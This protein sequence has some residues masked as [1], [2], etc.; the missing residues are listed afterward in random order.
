MA[1]PDGGVALAV[2]T[3]QMHPIYVYGGVWRRAIA[4]ALDAVILAVLAG[5]LSIP[6]ASAIPSLEDRAVRFMFTMGVAVGDG[7]GVLL[8]LAYFLILTTWT[9]ATFGKRILGLRVVDVDGRPPRLARI[10]LREIVGRPLS[11][12]TLFL[13]YLS[14]AFTAEQRGLHDL[15]GG[16]WV[17]RSPG[18]AE[19][20]AQLRL[21]ER[22]LAADGEVG[23]SRLTQVHVSG[24]APLLAEYVRWHP[25][26]AVVSGG[27]LRLT[28]T[29]ELI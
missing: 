23:P 18:A 27:T 20:D 14:V 17:V 7:G 3:A 2:S 5:V 9:Q 13:G 12:L 4:L 25:E 11:M 6:G 26:E 15:I 1:V 28:G 22:A 16:T 21:V 10:W 8:W 29:V 24:R 19:L